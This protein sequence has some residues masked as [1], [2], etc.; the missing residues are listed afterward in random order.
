MRQFISPAAPDKNGV[1]FVTGKDCRHLRQV[2]RIKPG[3][4]LSVRL[5]DGSLKNAT[6]CRIHEENRVIELQICADT[7]SMPEGGRTSS[8]DGGFRG[9]DAGRVQSAFTDVEFWLFQFIAKPVKMEQI[10]RQ[11]AECGVTYIVPVIGAYSQSDCVKAMLSDK[12]GRMARII[13]EARQQSG[14]PV[15]TAVLPP[16]SAADAVKRW[17]DAAAGNAESRAAAILWERS[18]HTRPLHSILRSKTLRTVAIAVGCEGGIAPGE[19]ELFRAGGFAPVHFDVNIL[20]CETAALYGIA[21]A[22]SVI[23][24]NKQWELKESQ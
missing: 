16:H 14:S 22:Q 3:D 18:E 4:M 21:A 13:K 9:V 15:E 24:E 23:L 20:R 8:E 19:L 7:Q 11:A 12:R 17:Q 2:L 1:I 5:P 6:V 10:V